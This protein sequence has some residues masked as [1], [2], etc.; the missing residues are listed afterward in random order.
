MPAVAFTELTEYVHVCSTLP[1][2]AAKKYHF[3]NELYNSVYLSAAIELQCT[4][5]SKVWKGCEHIRTYQ[6]F[7]F[8]SSHFQ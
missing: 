2:E 7:E 8:Q 4:Q 1:L 6:A 5:K 3:Q